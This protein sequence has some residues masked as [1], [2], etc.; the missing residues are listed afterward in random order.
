MFEKIKKFETGLAAFTGAPYAVTTDCCTHAIELCLLLDAVKAC[1]F[2][3]FTYLS[4]VQT[5]HKLK[6]SYSLTNEDW[7]GEYQFHNTRI[8]DSARRLEPKMYRSG[9]LQC[10]SFGFTKPVDIGR[11]GA[12]LTDSY[13]DYVTLSKMRYDGRDLSVSPWPA[14]EVFDLGFHY[15]LNPEECDRGLKALKRYSKSNAFE[16]KKVI[17]PD[18]R[19]IKINENTCLR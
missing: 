4:V 13:D 7:I 12:I 19:N 6:I 2:T 14:Q 10:L 5:M 16:P 1:S 15:K 18:C 3:A 8:W 9:A 17:Y 11:G